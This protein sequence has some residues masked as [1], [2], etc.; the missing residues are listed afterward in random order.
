M[1]H[2]MTRHQVRARDSAI[3]SYFSLTD[4]LMRVLMHMQDATSRSPFAISAP[5]LLRDAAL[6]PARSA[7]KANAGGLG[8]GDERGFPPVW[9]ARDLHFYS[10]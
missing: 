1:A 8:M 4:R 5:P 6:F 9:L 3:V 7:C 2:Q 10:M